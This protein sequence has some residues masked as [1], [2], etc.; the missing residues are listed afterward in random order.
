MN[1]K[2]AASASAKKQKH[3]EVEEYDDVVFHI[4]D[5]KDASKLRRVSPSNEPKIKKYLAMNKPEIQKWLRHNG[6]LVTGRKHDLLLRCIDGEVNGRI[7]GC[8]SCH[9]GQMQYDYSEGAFIC[10]GY[11]D[12]LAHNPIRC[13]H[14]Q[15]SVERERW[16][17][18]EKDSPIDKGEGKSWS[19]SSQGG[20]SAKDEEHHHR[21]HADHHHHEHNCQVAANHPLVDLLEDMAYYHSVKRGDNWGFRSR[22]FISAARA[23]E[24]LPFEIDGKVH[25]ALRLG[26]RSDTKHHISNIGKSSAEVMQAFLDSGKSRSPHLEELKA[27]ISVD[28]KTSGD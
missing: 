13:G 18:P 7:P 1:S 2:K 15:S 20:E 12:S 27:S 3:E 9:L 21:D 28:E 22:A 11:F 17:D 16:R 25:D 6:Q 8:P 14:I 24:H 10:N 4:P 23:V 26:N 19:S 5:G